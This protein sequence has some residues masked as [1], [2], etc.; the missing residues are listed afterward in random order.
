M[1]LKGHTDNV[2]SVLLNED[3]SE[4]SFEVGF[5]KGILSLSLCVCSVC[6]LVLMG[7]SDCGQL[8]NSAV[9]KLLEYTRAESGCWLSTKVSNI[10]T[11]VE[12]TKR[13]ISLT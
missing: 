13:F 4:V 10:F 12:K 2:R 8:V 9:W 11:Q 1:K 7:Q 5:A 6:Q 3:G